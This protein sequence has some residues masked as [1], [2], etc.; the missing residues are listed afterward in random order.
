MKILLIGSLISEKEMEMINNNSI[1]KASVAPLNYETMLVKGLM[2]NGVDVEALSVPAVASYPNSKFKFIEE[3]KEIIFDS[4]LVKWIPFINIQGIKQ[5]TIERN[6][7]KLLKEWL[8]KNQHIKDKVVLMYSIYPPYSKSAISLCK[9]FHCH[10]STVIADLPE[11]MYTWKNLKGLRKIYADKISK[12]MLNL[13]KKCDSYILFTKPMAVKMGIANKPFIVSE[14]FSDNSVFKR[15]NNVEKYDKKTIV[16]G[17]NLSK[18]YGIQNLVN[19]FFNTNIDAELHIYGAGLD[20]DYVKEYAKKDP[21]IKFKGR[22]NREE[23]LLAL[24]KAHLLIINKPTSDDYS[25]YS[26]SSKI[27]EY[28]VSGTP[29]LMTKV[30]GMP[31]E[32]YDY[33][34]FIE[35]ESIEGVQKAIEDIILLKNEE[36]DKKGIIAKKFAEKEKNYKSMTK[37]IVEFLSK[38][39]NGEIQ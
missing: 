22:V 37:K 38:Q 1:E 3:K 9:Q 27:L 17:G 4:I 15:I 33:L 25:N 11:Y 14:G 34:Y 39:I 31:I 10:L 6:T 12:E 32:Y 29:V 7:K 18:L 36:L 20:A 2:E 5:Y 16:Y 19:A 30:G 8:K 21:R 28:M 23:L 26:F 13:Q 35:N 24:K